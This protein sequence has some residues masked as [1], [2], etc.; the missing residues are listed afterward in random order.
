M[1]A[2]N[3]IKNLDEQT[4]QG[5]P[6]PVC[7]TNSLILSEIE[8]E[9]PY[10]GK[11][12]F[13]SMNCIN[14]NYHKSDIEVEENKNEPTKQTFEIENENDLNVRVIRSSHA[15]IIIPKITTIEPGE[16]ANGFITNIE[17]IFRRVKYQIEQVYEEEED[18][19]KKKK[20][21]VLLKKIRN[22]LWGQEKIKISIEDPSGNSAIISDK[23]IVKKMK[24]A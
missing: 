17:G 12:F 13:F 22:I 4:M 10:F 23:T 18:K 7:G 24:K 14:C 20:A 15:K 16:S 2:D 9:I 5:Q 6:C 11:A 21:K 19:D 8:K 3:Q 1:T